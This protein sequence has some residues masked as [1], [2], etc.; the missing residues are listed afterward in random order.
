MTTP[1][2]GAAVIRELVSRLSDGIDISEAYAQAA[3]EQAMRSASSRPTPQ[4]G[5]AS[6]GVV[7]RGDVISVEGG[8]AAE[9]FWGAEMGSSLYRQFGPRS[10]RGYWL[11]PSLDDPETLSEGDRAI[12]AL[13]D[14]VV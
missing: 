10:S 13:L 2:E 8:L 7:V 4:A 12:Q 5:I 9:L 6:S 14:S 11:F 3:V 1:E